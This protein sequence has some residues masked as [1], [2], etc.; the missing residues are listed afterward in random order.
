MY[1]P[2]HFRADDP[3]LARALIAAHPF[4]TLV[5]T[6]AGAPFVTHLP[7]LLS[8]DGQRLLGHFA[9]PNP[10]AAAI[11]H[12]AI[13]VAVFHGPHAY[14]SPRWYQRRPAVPTWNYAVVHV[15]G[16]LRPLADVDELRAL[17][18][19]LVE[20]FEPA[21]LPEGVM[22]ETH[23]EQLSAGIVGFALAIERIETKL[24]FGQHRSLADQQGVEAGLLAE[25]G[26][27]GA[28]LIALQR[29][30]GYPQAPGA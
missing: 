26:A 18:A 13:T 11:G 8:P 20:T 16:P 30:L 10:H 12:G 28:A 15:S 2:T 7:L 22:P 27:D 9:R 19:Q 4:A 1:L 29:R 21:P 3:A 24:K 6:L 14:V 23:V 25:G 17:Q 5:S